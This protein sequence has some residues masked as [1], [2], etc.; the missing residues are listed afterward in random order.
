MNWVKLYPEEL[1]KDYLYN[2]SLRICA[3]SALKNVKLSI[4]F[5]HRIQLIYD[6]TPR[7]L[8]Y[9]YLSVL[10]FVLINLFS[11]SFR[12]LIGKVNLPILWAA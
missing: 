1:G 8:T 2:S 11:F 4:N 6:S 12:F 3:I 10:L 9:L 7:D 5:P